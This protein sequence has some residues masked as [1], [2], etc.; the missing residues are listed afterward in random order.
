MIW[1]DIHHLISDVGFPIFVAVYFLIYTE[2][3]MR[4]LTRA[5]QAL[6]LDQRNHIEDA[7]AHHRDHTHNKE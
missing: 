7:K 2:R 1:P 6:C 4:T 5:V 3:A